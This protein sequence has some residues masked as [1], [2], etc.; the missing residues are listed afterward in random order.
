MAPLVIVDFLGTF[1]EVAYGSLMAYA[2]SRRTL[3]AARGKFNYCAP[4]TFQWN[5][6]MIGVGSRR[7]AMY[8]I[9]CVRFY[10]L[11]TM[12]IGGADSTL[13]NHTE[14]RRARSHRS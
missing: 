12:T 13:A 10:D 7:C 11:C 8:G 2:Y 4:T 1:L 5:N 3:L 14:P 9:S 6:L